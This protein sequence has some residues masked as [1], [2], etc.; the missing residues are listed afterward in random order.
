MRLMALEKLYTIQEAAEALRVEVGTIYKWTG[1]RKLTYIKG[2]PVLIPES[3]LKRLIEERTVLPLTTRA[4]RLQR[5]IV[6]SVAKRQRQRTSE[7]ET[8]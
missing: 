5:K 7:R 2:R 8:A 1:A 4:Q 3:A 6:K